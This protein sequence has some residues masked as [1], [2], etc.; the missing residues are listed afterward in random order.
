MMRKQY[1]FKQVGDDV[2]IWDVDRLILLS[3]T[4]PIQ[5][6]LLSAIPDFEQNYWYGTPQN[7]PTC[8]SVADH[9]RLIQNADPSYPIILHSDGSVMDGMH[10]VCKAYLLNQ[11]T[12]FAKKFIQ[13]PEP[14][15][16]N[17]DASELDYSS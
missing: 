13:T 2:L 10:R 7:E 15:F 6:V 3:E 17:V 11:S 16:Y 8:K 14:D 9:A 5:E 4:L 12:I 1:H